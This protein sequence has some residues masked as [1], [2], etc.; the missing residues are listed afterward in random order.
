VTHAGSVI[1]KRT[2]RVKPEKSKDGRKI[3]LKL[4]LAGFR[5]Y[6]FLRESRVV[7]LLSR[8]IDA[9][10]AWTAE[11]RLYFKRKKDSGYDK[12]VGHADVPPYGT[13]EEQKGDYCENNECDALLQNLQ[14]R[15]GP[16]IGAN[17]IRRHLK[18]ILKEGQPPARQYDNPKRLVLE[19]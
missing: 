16:L 13:A 12:S 7:A 1:A 15:N 18:K 6:D 5:K 17:S 11:T 3:D 2:L 14:L 8:F 10:Q 9:S 4:L 19:L